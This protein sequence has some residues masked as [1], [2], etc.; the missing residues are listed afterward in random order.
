M[1]ENTGE[2]YKQVQRY[3]RLTH[4]IPQ[5][6][7]KVDERKLAFIPAVELSYLK[8]QEQKWLYSNLEREEYYGV[9]L[10]LARK[11]KGISQNGKLT[12]QKIDDLI[13]KKVQT[14]SKSIKI[15]NKVIGKYFSSEVTPHERDTVIDQALKEWFDK[16]PNKG[17]PVPTDKNKS[18]TR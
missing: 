16:H 5:L 7:N 15:S 9:P 14:Q 10:A 4:L 1:A 11:L 2:S 17:D 18:L 3:I 6:L 13:V 12:E 8:K